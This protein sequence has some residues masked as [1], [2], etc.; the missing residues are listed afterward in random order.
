MIIKQVRTYSLIDIFPYKFRIGGAPCESNTRINGS[1]FWIFMLIRFSL[2]SMIW[3]RAKRWS[4]A[5]S[6][7][8]TSVEQMKFKLTVNNTLVI[9]SKQSAYGDE[10]VGSRRENGVTTARAELKF[11]WKFPPG[12]YY[13]GRTV[14]SNG[15]VEYEMRDAMRVAFSANL[16]THCDDVCILRRM[17]YSKLPYALGDHG[18]RWYVRA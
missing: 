18:R 9:T 17:C 16:P 10:I 7:A 12:G 14:Q 6:P 13:N 3:S 11:E 2:N 15:S 5:S 1:L 8:S 4:C